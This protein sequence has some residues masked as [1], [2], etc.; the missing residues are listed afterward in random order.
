MANT[1]PTI[2]EQPPFRTAEIAVAVQDYFAPDGAVTKVIR[3]QIGD[4]SC[5]LP[6]EGALRLST[7]LKRQANAAQGNP[8]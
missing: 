7:S 1:N 8:E 4:F 3:L 2:T 5:L 6:L